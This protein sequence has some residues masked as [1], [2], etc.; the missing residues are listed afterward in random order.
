[1][2]PKPLIVQAR[3]EGGA[4]KVP[5]RKLLLASLKSWP[6]GPCDL[7]IRPFESKRSVRANR[8]L[9]GV[10]YKYMLLEME[11][12]VTEASK[13]ELHEN[14]AYRFNPITVVDRFTGEERRVAG[15]TH[16]LPIE[17]FSHFI[18]D[19]MLLA[20]QSLG[21]VFPE[22]RASEEYRDKEAAA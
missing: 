1:M 18:D 14:M 8:W 7:E 19:V 4:L 9:F 10:V 21:I 15:P 12:R 13:L 11:G 3:I 5:N 16:T 6:D 2:K 22:P 17:K 20:S